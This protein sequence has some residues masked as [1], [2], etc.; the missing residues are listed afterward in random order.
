MKKH[1]V[2]RAAGPI[3][4]ALIPLFI[5]VLFAGPAFAQTP[6]PFKVLD[7][8]E[9]TYDQGPALAIIFS[10]PL[11]PKKKHDDFIRV[12]DK[13]R[14]INA[15]WVLS[16]DGR[17]LYWPGALPETEYSVTVMP[18]LEAADG[19]KLADR[20]S[21]AVT[22]RAITPGVNF[23]SEGLI[24]PSKMSRG[25]PVA[26]INI[27]TVEV[28]F[29]RLNEKGIQEYL[30]WE[31]SARRHDYDEIANVKK[32]GQ[33]A[34]SG[35]F[36]LDP[37]RNKR[38]VRFIPIMDVPELQKPGVYF[39][40]LR[41]P[42]EYGYDY[43]TTFFNV[44]DV[45]LH[46]RVYSDQTLIVASSLQTGQALEGVRLTFFNKDAV[47]V[48]RAVTDKDGRY[49]YP[50]R[51]G[52]RKTTFVKAEHDGQ[53]AVLSFNVPALD[54]S[55][56]PVA[57]RTNG[58]REV[59]LYS[60]R[61]LY[62]PGENVVVSA[63]YRD[64]DGRKTRELPLKA[65]LFRPDGRKARGFT[66]HPDALKNGEGMGYYQTT[67]DIPGDA[68]TG[69]WRLVVR[70]QPTGGPVGVFTFSVEDFMPERMRLDLESPSPTLSASEPWTVNVTGAYLY[71][72]PAD[73]NRL[74]GVVRV[75]A[76][77]EL[78]ESLEGFEFGLIDDEDYT[79]TW[80]IGEIDLDD[81]GKGSLDVENKWKDMKSPVLVS[82]RASLYES[83]GRPVSR[84]IRRIF[85]P[86]P[87]LIG[88]KPTFDTDFVEPGGLSF[89]VVQVDPDGK[90]KAAE[91]LLVKLTKEERD[92]YWEYSD[93]QGWQQKFT[94]KIYTYQTDIMKVDGT[95]PGLYTT[96]LPYGQYVLEVRDPAAD[97]ATSI[98]FRV[99]RYYWGEGDRSA[100][101]PDKIQMDLDKASYQPGDMIELTVTP[102]ASGDGCVLVESDRPLWFSRMPLSA[103]GTKVQIPLPASWDGHD[104]YISSVVFRPVDNQEKIAP[105]RAVGIVH[106][107]LDRSKRKM[108]MILAA[109]ER[110]SPQGPVPMTAK[111]QLARKPSGPVFVTLAAVDV[112]ILSITDF[113]TPDPFGW[114][115]AKRRYN[116]D[117][118]DHYGKVMEWFD[119]DMAKLQ[120]GGDSD[121][122]GGGKAPETKVK[123]VS[124]F[125]APVSFNEAGQAEVTLTVPGDFNGKLRLM[126]VAFGADGFGSTEGEVTV[127][128]PVVAQLAMPRYLAPG[129]KSQFTLDVRNMSGQERDLS[130]ALDAAAPLILQNGLQKVHLKD[131]E[132][133][134]LH[135]PVVV[136]PGF[137]GSRIGLRVTSD[138][139]DIQSE[140]QLGVRPA[141]PATSRKVR[142]ILKPNETFVLD[143]NLV[144]D[145]MP[146]SVETDVKVSPV[147]PLNIKE[148][149]RYLIGY[150][151]GCLEQTTSRAHPLLLATTENLAKLGMTTITPEE[152]N[153]RLAIAIERIGLMQRTE[154][155]FGLWSEQSPEEPWLSVFAT[156]FLLQARDQGLAVPP[157]MLETALK[158]LDFHV[159]RK[160]AEDKN[161]TR[162]RA[163]FAVRAY[164]AYV[165]AKVQ[166]APLGTLRTIWDNHRGKAGSNLPLVHLGLALKM[167]GDQGRSNLAL[168]AGLLHAP[169]PGDIWDDYGSAI[170][171]SATL[172]ALILE[173]KLD[174]LPIEKAMLDLDDRL[175]KREYL[176]TQERYAM[177]KLGVAM[178][179]LSPKEWSGVL[180]VAG[181]D[182]VVR[183]VKPL[184]VEPNVQ[185]IRSGVS[186][187]NT[188]DRPLYVSAIV[189]G[190]P[191]KPPAKNNAYFELVREL[192]N[193]KGEKVAPG[194][195]FTTGDLF[196]VHT[197]LAS[198]ETIPDA[199]LVDLLP[200][201][202]EIENPNFKYSM[203]IEDSDLE[204]LQVAGNSVWSHRDGLPLIHEEYR[205]D[206]YVAVL[207]LQNEQDLHLFYLVRAVTP[208]TFVAPPLFIESMYRPEIRGVGDP[209][210][211]V[212]VRD[213]EEKK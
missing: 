188:S 113:T 11:D 26:T 71:G 15:A 146:A 198:K 166:R 160:W 179:G 112:G 83:G 50:E 37:P 19:R 181:P 47:E 120:C 210:P 197:R 87:A 139:I 38:V 196:L 136:G 171:D 6:L 90:Q 8:S 117:A 180:R 33:L 88:V 141:Y 76:E 125:Q 35:R 20:A 144:A 128:A 75:R 147:I 84:G 92:F 16:A 204:E 115:F 32:Y 29:F 59:F 152:R 12:S 109:P 89:E 207:N 131:Q 60:P 41:Q 123:L 46:A 82:L 2:P 7:I 94:E 193:L 98:R 150:P 48:Q 118:Y 61:D 1:L 65:E 68:Q 39:A 138:G 132:R 114:F 79:D 58:P 161:E 169:H 167:M 137:G 187:R 186:F 67:L 14:L 80:E 69:S 134:I 72:A 73:G 157:A 170:R 56:F 42:G 91:G 22:T 34:Y 28:D 205:D 52:Q 165:L 119:G 143:K 130:V 45:G 153:R 36:Q 10:Q 24:L 85:W 81:A 190:Y 54:L 96:S 55:E 122:G 62:R 57:G 155:G 176:S 168:N 100:S 66:W 116:P 3:R 64:Y 213:K 184:V 209:T 182:Q 97:Q 175:R 108:E 126:A 194:S 208:G 201:G 158:R 99:G 18:E 70:D 173:H 9:R 178:E 162:D 27:S 211:A 51:P 195:P 17:V 202:F 154:G 151:Y 43:Q 101:R 145:L 102:P 212:T 189:N 105:N 31:S 183:Q 185:Q 149:V 159:Q 93:T 4:L 40:V 156:D 124:L 30:D 77:R 127:A 110:L 111:L 172:L 107:P 177:L 74:D 106:L 5:L 13:E 49:T 142:R 174:T 192:Y 53:I 148:A 133:T 25:L 140:E 23:A 121:E 203:K 95:K 199:L 103:K 78:F 135:F 206:R 191:F 129:D 104:I 21:Q 163:D 164:A 86:A 200:A 63:L 44:T